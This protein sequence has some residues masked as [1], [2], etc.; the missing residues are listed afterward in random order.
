MES[1]DT[2]M[3]K[4]KRLISWTG[5]RMVPWADEPSIIHEHL[6][7]YLFTQQFVAGKA[8]LDLG[9]GEG[10]GS[11]LLA[12]RA[13]KVTGIEL[14]HLA[15][16][17]ARLQYDRPNLEFVEGSVLKLE[18]V[19]DSSIDVAVCFEVI[20]HISDQETLLN[21]VARVL[22]PDGIFLVS[23]PDREIYNQA[24]GFVNPYHLKELDRPEFEALL[25]THFDCVRMYG[26]RAVVGS[27]L[28]PLD[29]EPGSLHEAS[30]LVVR[31]DTGK[32]DVV[33]V[34]PA[35]YLLAMASRVALPPTPID[36][37]LLDSG[38][39]GPPEDPLHVRRPIVGGATILA[40]SLLH[41][42]RKQLALALRA[43]NL[44]RE[45]KSKG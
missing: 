6:H 10:Y 31:Q 21:E 40:R 2:P 36:S 11:N 37:L 18:A 27:F 17:H 16:A 14:D 45:Q 26:Q 39:E 30:R 22:R 34:P 42:V 7:R 25:G 29:A 15:V 28:V 38:L 35:K 12:E 32:W 19:A 4:P 44:R 33:P 13:E 24:L 41:M 9:S 43:R 8:V 3:P 1:T 5:E 20:E 23:T